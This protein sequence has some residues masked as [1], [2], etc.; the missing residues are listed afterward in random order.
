MLRKRLYNEVPIL[1][2][3]EVS[4]FHTFFL[5]FLLL[6]FNK[7]TESKTKKKQKK[8]KNKSYFMNITDFVAPQ[9]VFL[10]LF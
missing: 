4:L 5:V 6:I 3:T 8:K 1:S 9:W 10:K 7:W 2:A